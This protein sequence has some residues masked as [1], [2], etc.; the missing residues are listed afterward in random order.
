MEG[1]RDRDAE[2]FPVTQPA[3][4]TMYFFSLFVRKLQANLRSRFFSLLIKISPSHLFH[5]LLFL[6]QGILVS[7]FW[8]PEKSGGGRHV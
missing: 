4:H 1:K 2:P 6:V 8:T 5:F 7:S 3:S